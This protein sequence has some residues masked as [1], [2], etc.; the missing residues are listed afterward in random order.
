MTAYFVGAARRRERGGAGDVV[1]A[2]FLAGKRFEH[3]EPAHQIVDEEDIAGDGGA[4]D[5]ALISELQFER[6]DA[7]GLERGIA[8]HRR[9]LPD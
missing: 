9:L 2:I 4:Q 8:G 5:A 7:L 6:I 1:E 3:A